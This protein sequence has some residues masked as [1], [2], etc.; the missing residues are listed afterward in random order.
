MN[1]LLL[2]FSATLLLN[3]A[4]AQKKE[5]YPTFRNSIYPNR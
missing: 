2:A 1:K 5:N 4:V 3:V